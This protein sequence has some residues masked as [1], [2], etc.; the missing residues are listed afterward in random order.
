ML[1]D[2]GQSKKYFHD[3]SGYNGRLDAIQAAFLR[4]KL[5]YLSSWNEQRRAHAHAYGKLFAGSNGTVVPPH[6]PAW[7]RPVYHLY[8]V[9]I[10]DRER[11]QQQLTAAGIGTGIHYPI[12]LHICKAYEGLFFHPDDFP[13]AAR[14]AGEILSLPMFPGLSIDSQRRVVSEIVRSTAAPPIAS[15]VRPAPATASSKGKIWI[16]LDNSP[17]VPFFAPIIDELQRLDYSVVLTARDCFQVRALADLFRLKCKIVGRHSGSNTIRK[18][19]GLCL[20]ASQLAPTILKE[21]PDLAVS[22]GSRSQLIVSVPLAIPSLF[23]GDYEFSTVSALIHPTWVMCP[24]VIPST[25]VRGD[26][27]RILK[28]PGIKEDV[29]VPRFIPDPTLRSQLGLHE[30]DLVVTV[31]PPATEAHYYNP[32]STDLFKAVIEFARQQPEVRMVALPRNERQEA[33]MREIWP[34]LFSNGTLRIPPSVV[35][36]LNLIW[37]SDLV[38]SGGGTMN[39]EAAALDVPVYSTFRGKIGA[40]DRYLSEAGRLVLLESA[41]DVPAQV[42]LTRRQR[43]AQPGRRDRGTLGSIVKQIVVLLQTRDPA[44]NRKVA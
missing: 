40:V 8:V 12:P 29:Y 14:A 37:Y 3:I 4:V 38:V 18:M 22:H 39:R 28:Y 34:E 6:V 24:E 31:R 15:P 13:V 33:W 35:D 44:S 32:A 36:G 7:S 5:R 16:D 27:S 41:E 9:R 30:D 43:P 20:R 21:K 19:A 11:V 26:P 23:I 17:H 25:A 2:H 42:R 10:S 1:R